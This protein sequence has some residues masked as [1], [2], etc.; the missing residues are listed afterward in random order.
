MP[1]SY[2]VDPSRRLIV[3]TLYGTLTDADLHRGLAA[4]A[5]DPAF[6]ATFDHL[7]DGC[8]ITQL[9]VTT[10]GVR[11]AAQTD[12]FAATSRRAIVVSGDAPYGVARMY[13]CLA[14]GDPDRLLVT[15][16]PDEARR[17]LGVG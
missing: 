8:G 10:A 16:D 12:R 6:D 13:Q 9:E 4:L 15:R 1:A 5:A 14:P 7:V 2:H 3:S 11:V 17:W